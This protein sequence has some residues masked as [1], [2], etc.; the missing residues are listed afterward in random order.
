MNTR[1]NILINEQRSSTKLRK[2]DSGAFEVC[3]T[4]V[5]CRIKQAF[6][7]RSKPKQD[8]EAMLAVHIHGKLVGL[9]T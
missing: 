1:I 7:P 3:V 9:I 2:G 4:L 6:K 5:S 8:T